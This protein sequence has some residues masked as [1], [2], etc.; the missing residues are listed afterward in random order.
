MQA[1]LV[2]FLEQFCMINP[3]GF[4]CHIDIF[5]PMWQIMEQIKL[6]NFN[7]DLEH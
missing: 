7:S 1:Q 5:E 6:D 4:A 3:K 2:R